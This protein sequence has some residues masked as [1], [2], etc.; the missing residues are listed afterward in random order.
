MPSARSASLAGSAGRRNSARAVLPGPKGGLVNVC[1]TDDTGEVSLSGGDAHRSCFSRSAKARRWFSR[2]PIA[3][4][5]FATARARLRRQQ[6]AAQYRCLELIA[7]HRGVCGRGIE[8]SQLFKR[9]VTCRT[10]E[11]LSHQGRVLTPFN[12]L[13]Q[14][15]A[16]LDIAILKLSK[17]K[18]GLL[19]LASTMPLRKQ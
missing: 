1:W 16:L 10:V 19:G 14:F 18:A 4:L 7:T 15:G 11:V 17:C 3:G 5:L 8:C 9:Q 13:A 6:K 12:T 2:L